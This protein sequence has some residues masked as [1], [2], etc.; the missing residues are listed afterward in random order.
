MTQFTTTKDI[1]IPAGTVLITAPKNRGGKI[2]AA[3]DKMF[4]QML[5]DYKRAIDKS[6]SAWAAIDLETFK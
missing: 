3:S 1:L 4:A 5:L 2:A 6:R